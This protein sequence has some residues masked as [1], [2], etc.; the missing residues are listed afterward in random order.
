LRFLVIRSKPIFKKL[1][2]QIKRSFHSVLSYKFKQFTRACETEKVVVSFRH[3]S[4]SEESSHQ[5]SRR[6]RRVDNT[7][8][9]RRHEKQKMKLFFSQ[10]KN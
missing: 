2:E 10:R 1:G 8:A 6:L 5:S 4:L 7:V 9:V 3:K